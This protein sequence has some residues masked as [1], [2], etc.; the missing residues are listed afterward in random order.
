MKV[1]LNP[2]F[3]LPLVLLLPG[4]GLDFAYALIG[5]GAKS[6]ARQAE[7]LTIEALRSANFPLT[8]DADSKNK[9]FGRRQ[10]PQGGGAGS[11]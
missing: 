5:E 4:P 11:E 3:R 10:G 2:L 9:S 6:Q 7:T 1:N 8:S